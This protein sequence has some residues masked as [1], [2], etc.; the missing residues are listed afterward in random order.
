MNITSTTNGATT[1]IALDGWLDTGTAPSFSDELAKIDPSCEQL[2]L[3]FTNL[4]YI[5]SAGL[6]AI[7][8]AHK[9]MSG[10]LTIVHT[11]PEVMQVFHMAGFD[12]RLKLA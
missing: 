2:I 4:E 7:V 10:N 3:D 9:K 6:R 11:S 12:K 8:T 1:T 5:S